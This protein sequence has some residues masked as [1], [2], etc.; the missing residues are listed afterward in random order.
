[1]D[2]QNFRIEISEIQLP[3]KINISFSKGELLK[4]SSLKYLNQEL[5]SCIIHYAYS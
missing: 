2:V 4:N 3:C 1:M 5:L